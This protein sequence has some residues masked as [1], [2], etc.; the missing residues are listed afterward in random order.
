MMH[1]DIIGCRNT[2]Y[3]KVLGNIKE[4]TATHHNIIIDRIATDIDI[5][6]SVCFIHKG[7][8]NKQTHTQVYTRERRHTRTHTHT[9]WPILHSHVPKV[10]PARRALMIVISLDWQA[11]KVQTSGY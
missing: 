4:R 1:C 9:Q 11:M 7:A 2:I 5:T 10:L 8:L 6:Y 3:G